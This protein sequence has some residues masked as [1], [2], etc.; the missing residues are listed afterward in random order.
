MQEM[1]AAIGLEQLK[2]LDDLNEKRM[3]NA[4]ILKDGLK[5]VDCIKFQKVDNAKDH[6]WYLFSGLLEESRAG[7]SRDKFVQKLKDLGIEA[8]V[9]WPLPIHLQ[10]YYRK[11]YG[12]KEGDFPIAEEICKTVF[13]L[14]IQPFLSEEELKRVIQAV[15]SVLA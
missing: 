12:F 5:G 7:F 10:P 1:N 14:P 4:A 6:A 11:R 3:K 8:D 15:K 9:A 2:V 13:Q